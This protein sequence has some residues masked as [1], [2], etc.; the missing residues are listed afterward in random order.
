MDDLLKMIGHEKKLDKDIDVHADQKKV[1]NLGKL[2]STC[3]NN[4]KEPSRG[5]TVALFHLFLHAGTAS[6]DQKRKEL[7]SLS[8]C[9]QTCIIKC[10][11]ACKDDEEDENGEFQT[12]DKYEKDWPK[13]AD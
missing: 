8:S 11:S 7:A 9:V 3:D 1:K 6:P 10:D 12:I 13:V 4:V 2:Q 5:L